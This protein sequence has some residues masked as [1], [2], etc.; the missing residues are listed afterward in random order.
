MKTTTTALLS[1]CLSL[2]LLAGCRTEAPKAET[3]QPTNVKAD[4]NSRDC[5]AIK[6][7]AQAEDCR[8]WKGIAAA[9]KKHNSDNVVKHSPGSIQQP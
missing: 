2:P 1:L 9:K 4:P 5:E 3:I 8:M 7:P 6:D